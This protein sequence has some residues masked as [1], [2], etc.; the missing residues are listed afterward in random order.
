MFPANHRPRGCLLA[1]LARGLSLGCLVGG[2]ACAPHPPPERN[3]APVQWRFHEPTLACDDD[4]HVYVASAE[5]FNNTTR[6][7]FSAASRYGES[8]NSEFVYL[9]TP[10]PGDRGRPQLCT[11][12]GGE[13]FALW[14]DTRNGRVDLI[15]N[16][17]LDA[18][19]SFM[20]EDVRV[21]AAASFNS[22]VAAPA[23][24]ADT[25][26][27]VTVV[28]Y[29]DSGGFDAFYAN[30]SRDQGRTWLL[31]DVR[32]TTVSTDLKSVPR[33][34]SDSNGGVFVTWVEAG[35]G[36]QTVQVLGS[37]DYGASW[38]F[39][40]QQVSAPVPPGGDILAPAI[41][42]LPSGDVLVAWTEGTRQRANI[43]LARLSNQGSIRGGRL[44]IA[45][46]RE[47]LLDP[48][49]PEL[50]C[51]RQ[52]RVYL[53]WQSRTSQ[54][55]TVLVVKISEDDGRTFRETRISRSG[56]FTPLLDIR[57]AYAVPF[58]PFRMAH[59]QSGNVYFAWVGDEAGV[60]RIGFEHLSSLV[61]SPSLIPRFI[62]PPGQRPLALSPQDDPRAF[63]SLCA[64]DAGH[65]FV[66]WNRGN[67]LTVGSSGSNG[68][69]SWNFENF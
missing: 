41:S 66:L 4:G 46:D 18:G 56:N 17:S 20:P 29:D 27:N 42:A 49:A 7:F 15:F 34:A 54:G 13:V 26:G 25:R 28:W 5:Q 23:F 35:A 14:E 38:W 65:V 50:A 36:G 12:S 22:N 31:A 59:D 68:Q 45:A 53:A 51:D 16:A 39:D 33:L 21:N 52:G 63:L 10:S 3:Q 6:I 43:Q 57:P 30:Q 58:A 55:E 67:T 48:S 19:R 11:G 40:A 44:S 61:P 64:D 8:W 2:P 9:D 24:V 32:M 37:T 69:S 62:D 60:A 47:A 1:W